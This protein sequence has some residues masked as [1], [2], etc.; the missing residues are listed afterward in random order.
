MAHFEAMCE[1]SQLYGRCI[2]RMV[3][4]NLGNQLVHKLKDRATKKLSE[5][6][7]RSGDKVDETPSLK[8]TEKKSIG[9]KVV[10]DRITSSDQSTNV[11]AQSSPSLAGIQESSVSVVP[12]SPLRETEDAKTIKPSQSVSNVSNPDKGISARG[13]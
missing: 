7:G 8:K 13:F 10:P 3:Y 9:R 11:R 2:G 12:P 5:Q 1:E 6:K 4:V